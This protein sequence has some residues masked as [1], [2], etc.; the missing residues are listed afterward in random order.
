[1]DPIA[2]FVLLDAARMPDGIGKAL[3][4][5]KTGL[6][7]YK[8]QSMMLLTSVSPYLFDFK[9]DSTFGKWLMDDG[10]G[11]SWGIFIAANTDF[12]AC[13]RHFRKFL[14]VQTE[15]GQELYFRFYDPRVLRIF[16][17]TCEKNQ[18]IEFFGP[19]EY[20]IVEGESGEEAI[21]FSHTNGILHQKK[22]PVGQVMSKKITPGVGS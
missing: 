20:F 7:L 14:L 11:C 17:P 9:Q 21:L 15:K 10:W 8:G 22:V 5:S 4:L 3:E 6:S 16:L 2:N 13:H 18:I 12:E 1:M 19:V